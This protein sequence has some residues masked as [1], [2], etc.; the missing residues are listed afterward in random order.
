M[1]AR[2]FCASLLTFLALAAHAEPVV[3]RFEG[4]FASERE[5]TD[6][7]MRFPPE[8]HA[9]QR[10]SGTITYD[11]DRTV[12]DPEIME[13]YPAPL[14]DVTLNTPDG[15][16]IVMLSNNESRISASRAG[17]LESLGL[18]LSGYFYTS[19]AGRAEGDIAF[20]WS[21]SE[22]GQLPLDLN[23]K[24]SIDPGILRPD[25]WTLTVT[26]RYDC[27]P[28]C[29][30]QLV[31]KLNGNITAFWRSGEI[32]GVYHTESFT[33]LPEG[34][35]TQGGAWTVDADT[36]RN[37][38]N[39]AFTSSLY[40]GAQ[41]TT[42]YEL[43]VDLYSQWSSSGNT[44][45]ILLHY[46]DA[47]N[48]DEI[49]FNAQGTITY[50]RV[51]NG[52]RVMLQ[53]THLPDLA[54]RTWSWARVSR[55]GDEI[56]L[57][58]GG[59]L[60]FELDVGGPRGGYA[61]VFS[62]WNQARFD[63]FSLRLSPRWNFEVSDF[64]ADSSGWTSATGTWTRTNGYYYSSSN[65]LA[66]ISTS[67][68]ITLADYSVDT[69]LYLEWSKSG[70]RGGVV[71]DYQNASNYRAVLVSSGSLSSQEVVIP[72]TFEVIEVRDGV[73]RVVHRG[74]H[75]VVLP[76]DWAPVGVRRLG[77]V[78]TITV[79]GS[80]VSLVQPMVTGTKRAGL[81]ANYNKVRFDDVVIGMP[82]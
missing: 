71:Y 5:G 38:A 11:A 76:R 23:D 79:L 50:T 60:V 8:Y 68:P 65:L 35:A 12:V 70:N 64:A 39:V 3:Y 26:N 32:P 81:I 66:A 41:L 7:N 57:H 22:A 73:R 46:V 80:A 28:W 72:G 48:F 62:S 17:G 77:N 18:T 54:P 78:T 30:G 31:S 56:T 47:A 36:Y 29:D 6:E 58:I 13:S 25:D 61:G 9:G 44:Y 52:T 15:E 33:T 19:A 24:S 14:I 4:Y 43:I 27:P 55:E 40:S 69:S 34:W 21:S 74:T 67:D 20:V 2:L 59:V 1:V 49:R 16:T 63:N 53:T 75:R 42:S 10:F 82:K 51:Q 45:G 37:A